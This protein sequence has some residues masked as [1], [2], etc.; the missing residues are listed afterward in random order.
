MHD[1]YLT[2]AEY[3]AYGGT[4]SESD[5]TLAEFKARKRID[6]LTD[7]RVQDM[8]T[9]PTA[10]KLC[11]MALIDMDAKIGEEAQASP[12]VKSFN[13]DGYSES[14]GSR[15]SMAEA[16]KAIGAVVGQYLYGE[17]DD[18]G[19]PLLYRGIK[20]HRICYIWPWIL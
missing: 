1:V 6:Y 19:I 11:I 10:V 17:L 2:Y 8:E 15:M 3:Q 4:L 14:Y 16:Q 9:V 5:F 20:E 18:K 12:E 7:S 13:T